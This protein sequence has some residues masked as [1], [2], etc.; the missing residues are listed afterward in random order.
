[1]RCVT[2][3]GLCLSTKMYKS[4]IYRGPSRPRSALYLTST[5]WKQERDKQ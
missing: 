4:E 3:A 5:Q 2:H 1:M